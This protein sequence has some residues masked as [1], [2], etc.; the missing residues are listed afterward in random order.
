MAWFME[1]AATISGATTGI[2][3]LNL[4]FGS[5]LLFMFIADDIKE[6]LVEFNKDVTAN[7][8][9]GERTKRF[10][11]IVQIHSDAKE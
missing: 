5:S 10:C 7:R 2:L 9:S 6:D 1:F 8:N 4:T 11:D 3:F